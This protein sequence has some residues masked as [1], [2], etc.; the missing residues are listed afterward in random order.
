[1]S[2]KRITENFH[3]ELKTVVVQKNLYVTDNNILQYNVCL[4]YK[5]NTS[6][7]NILCVTLRQEVSVESKQAIWVNQKL[8][9]ETEQL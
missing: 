6:T 3:T 9:E 7:Q 1:M 2:L 8:L 5:L 4:E